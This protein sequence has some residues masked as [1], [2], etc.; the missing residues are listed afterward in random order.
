MGLKVIHTAD[1]HIGKEKR[2]ED[3][4]KQIEKLITIAKDY[5]FVIVAGDLFDDEKSISVYG[6]KLKETI[7]KTS[8]PFLGILGNH[9]YEGIDKTKELFSSSPLTIFTEP[10]ILNI[11][12]IKILFLKDTINFFRTEYTFSIFYIIF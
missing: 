3:I 7:E 2:T 12:G 8:T 11:K 4:F 9:E 10:K 5:D 6:R 1:W